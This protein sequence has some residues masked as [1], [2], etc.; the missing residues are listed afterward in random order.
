M[1]EHVVD[2]SLELLSPC[3]MGGAHQQPEFRIAS[4]RGLW[5]YWYRALYA[6]G[7]EREETEGE[8]RLFGAAPR[9][10]QGHQGGRG[11]VKLIPLLSVRDVKWVGG[12]WQPSK[13]PTGKDYLLFSTFTGGNRRG[14][15]ETGQSVQ[16]KLRVDGSES[17]LEQAVRSLAAACAF[18]G[19]GAR[20]R[21]M[22]GAVSLLAPRDPTGLI[23]AVPAASPEHLASR[24]QGLL[25]PALARRC[26]NLRYHIVARGAFS[27]GVLKDSFDSWQ[28][29]LERVGEAYRDFRQFD[30]PG[31]RC[32]RRPD[33]DV[34]KNALDGQQPGGLETITRAAFGL[35]IQFKFKS[36]QD[37]MA[38]IRLPKTDDFHGDRRGR[39][40]PLFLTLERLEGG[41]LA[42]VWS[43][44]RGPVTPDGKIAIQTF[45]RERTAQG[46]ERWVPDRDFAASEPPVAILEDM[47]RQ[48]AWNSHLIAG[49]SGDAA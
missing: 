42:V 40:S 12:P 30:P 46:R 35:P 43:W 33:Y 15:L 27:A 20:G 31:S 37:R 7:N 41:R 1:A 4:L 26:S 36:R 34:A 24:I 5:R 25:A 18:S 9:E 17:D 38:E 11:R 6:N 13:P 29:A 49:V 39:G 10:E 21:R 19:L 45:R 3:F 44:F 16:L 22:A 23:A 32:R 48:P 28:H 14:W 2:L 8:K 47:L